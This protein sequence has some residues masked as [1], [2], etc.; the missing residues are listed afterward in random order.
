[1]NSQRR[2]LQNPPKKREFL[3]YAVLIII[4]GSI[5]YYFVV[6]VGEM[7]QITGSTRCLRFFMKKKTDDRV[8]T[9]DLDDALVL[10][11]N[12]LHLHLAA[13]PL[14]I[15]IKQDEVR[16]FYPGII[17]SNFDLC[18]RVVVRR[19]SHTLTRNDPSHLSNLQIS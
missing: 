13:S 15:K 1:L 12:P 3:T 7:M 18:P 19:P 5:I 4:F 9:Q 16:C 17:I 2:N 14:E 6:F 10:D 11:T 8:T